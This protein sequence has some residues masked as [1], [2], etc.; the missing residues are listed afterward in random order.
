MDLFFFLRHRSRDVCVF[1]PEGLSLLCCGREARSLTTK[2][3]ANGTPAS[4]FSR[5]SRF[6][7]GEREL[8]PGVVHSVVV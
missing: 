8:S 6:S 2:K 1:V 5:F 4:F 3:Q 7:A